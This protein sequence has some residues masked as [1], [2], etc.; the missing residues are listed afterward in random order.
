M[1]VPWAATQLDREDYEQSVSCRGLVGHRLELSRHIGSDR[2]KIGA[3]L[4][5]ALGH[6]RRGWTTI[7]SVNARR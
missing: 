1:V 2:T 3:D 7:P 4:L 5:A 6:G